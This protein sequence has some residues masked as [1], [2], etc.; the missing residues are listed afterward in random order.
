M[1]TPPTYFRFAN[2][3]AI[4]LTGGIL[5]LLVTLA[6]FNFRSYISR[7]SYSSFSRSSISLS[8]QIQ[9]DRLELADDINEIQKGLMFRQELCQKCG[10]LFVFPDTRIL[11]FWMRNTYVSLDIIFIDEKGMVSNIASGTT[12]LQESPTYDSF[13]PVRYVLEVNSGYAKSNG[14]TRGYQ[15]DIN[16]LIDQSVIYDNSYTPNSTTPTF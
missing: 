5:V 3:L 9:L 13:D 10:M 12:P 15:F 7:S 11:T 14:I 4:G 8:K 1:T 16:N 6:D 2:P